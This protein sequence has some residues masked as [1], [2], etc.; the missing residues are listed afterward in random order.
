MSNPITM[1][2]W[3]PYLV[4]AAIGVLS[5]YVFAVPGQPLGITTPFE[6]AAALGVQR[7][8]PEGHEYFTGPGK[9]LAIGYGWMVVLGVFLGAWLS[10]WLSGDRTRE[11][12]E[13]PWRVRFGPGAGRRLL[14]AFLGGMALMFGARLA[15]GCTSG[16]AISGGLQLALSSWV[17]F[18]TFFAVGIVAAFAL[19]GKEGVS[20]V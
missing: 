15:G 14:F 10:A 20:H 5:W 7:L 18:V 2:S 4:G 11:V 16:H 1:K 17:F 8:V 13:E 19:Y 12:M 3:S 6:Q 9:K